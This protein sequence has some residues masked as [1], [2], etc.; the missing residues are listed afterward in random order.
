MLREGHRLSAYRWFLRVAEEHPEIPL[1]QEAAYLAALAL[2]DTEREAKEA[3]FRQAIA[4]NASPF[5]QRLLRQWAFT[6]LGWGD[7]AGAVDIALRSTRN[8]PDDDTLQVLADRIITSLHE[9]SPTAVEQALALLSRLPLTSLNLKSLPL[10][11]F[12]PLRGM[13]LRALTSYSSHVDDLSPLRGMPLE[14]LVLQHNAVHDL[15][16]L[17]HM[18]LRELSLCVQRTARVDTAARHVVAYAELRH[19]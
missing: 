13:A 17:A 4:D 5:Q 16:P 19:E 18:P 11:S 2:P 10:E 1:Q 7:I 8:L 12:A 9:A 6:R 3:A 15:T 14:Q